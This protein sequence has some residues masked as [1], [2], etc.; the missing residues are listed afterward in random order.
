MSTILKKIIAQ[1]TNFCLPL[2][3]KQW[4]NLEKI[5]DG[6][7]GDELDHIDIWAATENLGIYDLDW[8]GHF[9]RNLFFRVRWDKETES[10]ENFEKWLLHNI[11]E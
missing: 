1:S 7:M 3:E 10:L 11:G 2:N 9:G 6:W 4:D 8:N 5:R